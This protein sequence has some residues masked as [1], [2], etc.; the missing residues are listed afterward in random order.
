MIGRDLALALDP[1]AFMR[2]AGKTPDPWQRDFLRCRAQRMLLLTSR[3]IGKTTTV[4]ALATHTAIYNPGALILVLG[5]SQQQSRE[6]YGK[7]CE[8]YREASDMSPDAESASR[9]ELPNGSRIVSLSGNPTTVRGF[10][11]PRL[12]ILDEA[13]FIEDE[14]YHAVTPM[15]TA[16]GRLVALST[17]NGKRG[18]FWDNYEN[19]APDAWHRTKITADQSPRVTPEH[20]ARE[21][22]TKKAEWRMQQEYFCEFVD[23]DA[24]VFASDDIAAAMTPTVAPLFPSPFTW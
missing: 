11:G 21:R 18:W 10:S 6:M 16:G 19:A 8:F 12:V 13:A 3:Q 4:A 7:I 24:Q 15:L 20:L 2:E 1:A 17:P 14:L 5:P 22:A 23:T 9:I